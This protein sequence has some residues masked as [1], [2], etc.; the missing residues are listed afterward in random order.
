VQEI[1]GNGNR[2]TIHINPARAEDFLSN[3]CKKIDY[4]ILTEDL[5]EVCKLKFFKIF[6][7][8]Y[9][10]GMRRY[11]QLELTGVRY[12]YL[13]I[14]RC[15]IDIIISFFSTLEPWMLTLGHGGSIGAVEAHPGA[16]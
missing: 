8:K 11:V 3:F 13:Q 4:C 2:L 9:F 5:E 12:E 10:S 6:V 15:N 1:H 16:L 7:R 14:H